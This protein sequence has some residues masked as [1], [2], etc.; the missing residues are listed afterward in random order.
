MKRVLREGHKG[1]NAAHQSEAI[2]IIQKEDAT[3]MVLPHALV[4]Y[5]E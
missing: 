5:G 4:P 1:A 2:P 3:A